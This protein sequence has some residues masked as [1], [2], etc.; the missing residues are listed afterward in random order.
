MT[1]IHSVTTCGYFTSVAFS[2]SP[3]QSVGEGIFAEVGKNL[4]VNLESR[5]VG[6]V[7]MLV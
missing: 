3:E 2:K 6:F 1:Y 4:V 7:I 5:K